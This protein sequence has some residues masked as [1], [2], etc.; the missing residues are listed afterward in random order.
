[1]TFTSIGEGANLISENSVDLP[2]GQK[3]VT[4]V[5]QLG[6]DKFITGNTLVGADGAKIMSTYCGTCSGVSVGCVD[7]RNND[8]VLDCINGRI[9]CAS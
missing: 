4:E 7:C 6:D 3:M 9:Y 2:N 1:M 8:P 5:I